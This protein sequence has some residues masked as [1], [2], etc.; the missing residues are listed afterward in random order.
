MIIANAKELSH[1]L[2]EADPMCT[3][4][5]GNTGMEDEYD[6]IAATILQYADDIP[7]ISAVEKAFVYWFDQYLFDYHKKEILRCIPSTEFNC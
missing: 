2:Y 1:I 7:D 6:K 4:C 3:S 5:C